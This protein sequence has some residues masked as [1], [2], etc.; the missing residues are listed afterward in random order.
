MMVKFKRMN[1]FSFFTGIG[2]LDLGFETEGYKI[3]FVNEFIPSFLNAYHYSR[4][5]MKFSDP[6]FGEY[7]GSVVDL[8]HGEPKEK[9]T[10]LIGCAKK[11]K[12]IFGFIAGPP[13]PDFSVAGKNKG[14][15]G[16]RG[17]LTGTYIDL[18]CEQNPD[19][20]LF[21]NVKGL[22]KTKRHREFYEEVKSKTHSHGY[23]TTEKLINAI[24]FGAPQDRQRIL[25]LGFK[26]DLLKKLGYKISVSQST[27][28]DGIFP[29]E[30]ATKYTSSAV[31]KLS[32]P[33]RVPYKADSVIPKPKQVPEELTVQFW[34]EK[35]DVNNH[36][37]AK[38]CFRPKAGLAKFKIVDEG[39]VTRK[40]YKRLHRWRY[41]PTAAYG[42][43][44]VHL[45][46]YKTRRI[47]VAESLAIQS[48]P[49]NFELPDDMTLSDMF[50]TVGNGV[51]YIAAKGIAKTIKYFL[52]Q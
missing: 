47:T 30:H 4:K 42:N 50:K 28:P 45:H 33:D 36:P 1:I 32:W 48:L 5:K 29:W 24:D 21:E 7:L 18:I 46:P 37:N 20:F 43:N 51:P 41:S 9:L 25:L 16:E 3:L 27:L 49:K 40:S 2:F 11:K 15:E 17:K 26:R 14:K 39:D 8:L 38:H 10:K 35:N 34:F 6:E 12:E 19:F 31:F 23:V 44:E 22:W 52:K 13:C